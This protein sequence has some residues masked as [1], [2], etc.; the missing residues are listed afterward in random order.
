MLLVVGFLLIGTEGCSKPEE[1][2]SQHFVRTQ[3]DIVTP[4]GAV[5]PESVVVEGEFIRYR[6]ERGGH[7]KIKATQ[8]SNGYHYSHAERLTTVEE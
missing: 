1:T 2:L 8:Q 6:T 5:V 3:A 7:W 4:D